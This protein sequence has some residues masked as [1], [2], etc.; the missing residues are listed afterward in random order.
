MQLPFFVYGTLKPGESNYARYLVG[1]TIAEVPAW[2]DQGTLFTQGPYPFL[3]C[4][5]DLAR[6]DERVLGTLITVR[7]SVYA[8]VLQ[9]LDRLEGYLVDGTQNLYERI[10]MDVQTEH[11]PYRAWVYV[12]GAQM[13]AQI[14]AGTLRKIPGGNWRS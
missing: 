8:L 7:P 10:T 14:R 4:E 3:V 2:L 12:V 6:P 1:Q 11:G 5:P 13:L 9:D